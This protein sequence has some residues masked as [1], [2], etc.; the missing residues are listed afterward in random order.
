MS[1]FQDTSLDHSFYDTP[2]RM[3]SKH[4]KGAGKRPPVTSNYCFISQGKQDLT[5]GIL[6]SER[7]VRWGTGLVSSSAETQDHACSSSRVGKK[8]R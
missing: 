4:I 5:A 2:T 3:T 1:G 7:G 6:Q 8:I